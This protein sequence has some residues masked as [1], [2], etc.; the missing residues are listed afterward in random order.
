MTNRGA[1]ALAECR[2]EYVVDC[3]L[4]LHNERSKKDFVLRST[5]DSIGVWKSKHNVPMSPYS[6]RTNGV[7]KDAAIINGEVWVFG[8]DATKSSDI[9]SAVKIGMKYHK[10]TAKD[11]IGDVYVKNLNTEH[12]NELGA[13]ALVGANKHLYQNVCA[14]VIDATKLLGVFGV[15][16]FWVI[17]SNFNKKIPK[18]DLHDALKAGGADNVET[19]DAIIPIFSGP[20]SG[21]PGLKFKQNLHLATLKIQ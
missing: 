8:I 14:A 7:T 16:N 9:F 6:D 13:Q 12:E 21:G 15:I 2:P 19:D 4:M 20:N 11:I 10:A 1:L 18:A 5:F 3:T 17:S